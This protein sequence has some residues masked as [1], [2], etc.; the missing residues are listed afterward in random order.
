MT[1]IANIN[2]PTQQ[3]VPIF[4]K[5]LETSQTSKSLASHSNSRWSR[6]LPS[7]SPSELCWH[8]S[9]Q[10]PLWRRR[11]GHGLVSQ[12]C[13]ALRY[14]GVL[15]E[16]PQPSSSGRVSTL[17]ICQQCCSWNTFELSPNF[18]LI[19][20]TITEHWYF[21]DPI[22]L[23]SLHCYKVSHNIVST[24]L[25]LFCQLLLY[26]NTKVGWVFKNSGNLL[27]KFWKWIQK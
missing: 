26:Q 5:L 3:M 18:I 6:F 19:F 8:F 4:H 1:I 14:R 23:Y 9:L 7:V 20:T 24:L 2:V 25:L 15:V 17:T 21:L 11:R 13:G 12:H 22:D 27:Q 16:C 10:H